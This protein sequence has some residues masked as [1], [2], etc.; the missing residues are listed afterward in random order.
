MTKITIAI[1]GHSSTGKST[2]A[3]QLANAL[4]YIY[5]DTGAMYR[6]ITLYAINHDCF[7]SNT[8]DESKLIAQLD[9]MSISFSY[10]QKQQK[11]YILLNNKNVEDDIRSMAVSSKVS[12]VAKVAQVRSKL[13]AIQQ[14]MGKH[15]GI[16]MDGRDIGSVVFPKAEL[17]L[18]MTASPEARAQR[19]FNELQ[20]NS[21]TVSYQEVLSNVMQR[22]QIDSTRAVSPLIQTE[23][24]IRI[25]NT[26]LTHE[27][28]FSKALKL[29][30]EKI[31]ESTNNFS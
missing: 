29:A 16:V 13:V 4:N 30:T 12:Q 17:K 6:A 5:V 25:D 9:Q 3:K 7:T 2:L 22:D 11:S 24:A 27:A 14:A 28:Q 20:A 21:K 19:R 15:G 1:D 18:F 26:N 10:D 23:D 8:L 31:K